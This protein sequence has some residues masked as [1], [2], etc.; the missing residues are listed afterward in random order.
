MKSKFTSTANAHKYNTIQM[1]IS[2]VHNSI[3]RLVARH[4]WCNILTGGPWTNYIK[5]PIPHFEFTEKFINK[6]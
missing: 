4:Q 3:L 2:T 6:Y 1:G 5:G